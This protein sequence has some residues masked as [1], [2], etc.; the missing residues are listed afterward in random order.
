[1]LW[2]FSWD[3]GKT[4]PRMTR[5]VVRAAVA[6]VL[7]TVLMGCS[8]GN[9]GFYLYPQAAVTGVSEEQASGPLAGLEVVG[10]LPAGKIGTF[11]SSQVR[12]LTDLVYFTLTPRAN[13]TVGHAQ[14]TD[15]HRDFLKKAKKEF[16]TRILMGVTDHKQKG[17]LSAVAADPAL[18][19]R[20]AANLTSFLMMEGFD[21]ADFDWEYP[22][23]S[24]LGSYTALLEAIRKQF[25]PRGLRLSVAVS[26]SR[27][28]QPEAYAAVDRVHGML[29]D[30]VGQHSTL[31]KVS[32][33]VDSM[34]E[35]G[36]AP[37]Q[38]LLGIPFYGRGYTRSG[39]AWS[40]A[41][42]Y[43]T[44]KARYE[45]KPGQDT[46]SGYYFNGIETVRR[47]VQYAKS[48]GLSGVM[49]WEVGQDTSDDSSLL[50]AIT[51]TRKALSRPN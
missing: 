42:S 33:L 17:A 23:T 34:V 36:V 46:V 2:N 32:A 21:G 12:H 45:L 16:G 29:Y 27:P 1:M 50:G 43:K 31:E 10:Y 20:F 30:D 8:L 25:A 38:L 51:Q 7:T 44:L 26:P 35:Q 49:V 13:G 18:R 5:I 14:L 19:A 40:S 4:I 9:L 15:M 37:S 41:L 48:I 24:Q 22:A 11:E 47:K 28:L 3:W 6:L 39:P